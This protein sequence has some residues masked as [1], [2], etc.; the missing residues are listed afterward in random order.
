MITVAINPS[1]ERRI[2]VRLDGLPSQL[3]TAL[4]P[5]ITSLTQQLLQRVRAAEPV[6]TGRL[7]QATQAFV[8]ERRDRISGK[9]RVLAFRGRTA[10]RGSHNVAAAALEYG[11]HRRFTVRAHRARLGH[12]FG[13]RR[14]GG[15]VMVEAY[16]RH[17]NI[18]AR[19]FLRS[20]AAA[21]RPRIQ[22]EL[23]RIIKETLQ[24]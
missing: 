8:D 12:V 15:M 22:A 14:T 3:R 4:R 16:Q 10:P 1:D 20:P 2:L 5:A 6:R 21:M 18:T 24:R 19:R 13:Q 17:A 9:V 11:A 23:Q 7:R